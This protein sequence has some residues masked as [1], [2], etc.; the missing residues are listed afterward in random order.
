MALGGGLLGFFFEAE[1]LGQEFYES[2]LLLISS[3]TH[4]G[5]V[6][7]AVNQPLFPRV[8]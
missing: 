5:K 7:Q 8:T 2:F 3:S 6:L 4:L 1:L